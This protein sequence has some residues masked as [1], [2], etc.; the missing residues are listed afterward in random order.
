M[1]TGIVETIATVSALDP[2]DNTLSGGGGT[3]LTITDC[4]PLL[5]DAHLGDSISIN[6]TCLTI[7]AFTASTF[8]VGVSPETLR[9]TNLGGLLP[10]SRVNLERAVSASTRMGGHF[11]QGHVDTVARIAAVTPDG[12]AVRFRLEPRDK[13]VLRWVVEK[14]YVALDGAS[15]T[16]TRVEEGEGWCE[17]MLIAYTR[18]RVVMGGKGEGEEVNVEVDMVGNVGAECSMEWTKLRKSLQMTSAGILIEGLLNCP[19]LKVILSQALA[20]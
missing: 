10:G 13:A 8:K 20:L 16:V 4:A 7:T 14:G 5:T 11:V 9:R 18:E 2:Q 3:S 1:F 12:N 17:V 6:G 15:L 19:I